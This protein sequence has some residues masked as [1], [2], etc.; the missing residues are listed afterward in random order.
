ME[1][2]TLAEEV[3]GVRESKE[4]AVKKMKA[5]AGEGGQLPSLEEVVVVVATC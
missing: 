2:E 3:L 4:A 5:V 1:D